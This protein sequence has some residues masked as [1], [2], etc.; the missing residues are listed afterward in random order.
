[1]VRPAGPLAESGRGLHLVCAL[2][3]QWGC[4]TPS[5]AGKVVWATFY[6]R[7]LRADVIVKN[8]P[9]VSSP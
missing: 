9:Q 1:V 7:Q 6:S 5:N 2:S 8:I 3:D 4:T